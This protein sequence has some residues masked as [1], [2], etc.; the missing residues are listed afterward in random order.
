MTTMDSKAF[1]V[2]LKSRG[3]RMSRAK[4]QRPEVHL[5]IGESK[6]K[7]WKAEWHVYIEN[8]PKR[9]HRAATWLCSEYTKGEAQQECDRLV[10]EETSGPARPDGS[11]TVAEFWERNFYP[12]RK[13]RVSHNTQRAYEKNWG[14]YIKPALGK[15]E[16]Q[17]V[18]KNAIEIMLGKMADSGKAINTIKS[19]LVMTKACMAE[20]HDSDYILKNPAR[21]AA[22]PRCAPQ[23][24]TRS[25]TE[26]EVSRLFTETE[27]R[28]RLWWQ[29]LVLTG[30]R[31]SELLA[32]EKAD[33]TADGLRISKSALCGKPG[34]TKNHKTRIAP[35]APG[36]RQALED[37]A[38]N[39][40]SALL[41]PTPTGKMHWRQ[42]DPMTEFVNRGRVAAGIPDLMPRMCRTTFATLWRGDPSDV[43]GVLGHH[44]L[45]L[46]MDVYRRPVLDR[47]QA[48]VTELEARLSGKVVP[49]QRRA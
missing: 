4:Y 8:R 27:D 11:M 33:I 13:Q 31:I 22:L 19:V 17:Q 48:T 30:V 12:V 40:D 14:R 36:L 1:G 38:E 16:L 26:A 49:I 24:E 41:F 3:I 5:W 23:K 7:Y 6:T 37:W 9:K 25:L 20:A 34:D 15:L 44:D 47:Q 21:K 28:D 2:L 46:T 29:I 42:S 43:Q 32:L 18:N 35:L 10:R 45:K 39:T